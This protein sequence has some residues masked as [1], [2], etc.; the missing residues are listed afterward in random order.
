MTSA[1]DRVQVIIVNSKQAAAVLVDLALNENDNE[2]MSS[3]F[4]EVTAG[5]NTAK[6]QTFDDW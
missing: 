3:V 1:I 2:N 4:N 5:D 6:S